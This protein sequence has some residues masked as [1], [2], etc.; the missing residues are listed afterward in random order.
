M[1]HWLVV[2]LMTGMMPLM[3]TGIKSGRVPAPGVYMTNLG[4]MLG[5][6][7]GLMGHVVLV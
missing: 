3:H 6:V 5:F 1:I 7:G 4:G 2:G